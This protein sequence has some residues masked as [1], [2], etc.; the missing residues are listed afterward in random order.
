[1]ADFKPI[2]IT[3][4]AIFLLAGALNLFVSPFVEVVEVQNDSVLSSFVNF[5]ENGFTINIPVIEDWEINPINWL[6][7]GS[8]GIKSFFVEQLT[9]L[10]YIPDYFLIPLLI[11]LLGGLI[12]SI[13]ALLRGS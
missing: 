5:I 6:F 4:L 3:L 13:L 12:W 2:L 10:T 1:M 7:L 9:L 11:I 8:S